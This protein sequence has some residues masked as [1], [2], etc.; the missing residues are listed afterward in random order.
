MLFEPALGFF[1]DDY[2]I[3]VAFLFAA[4]YFVV[5]MPPLLLLWRRAQGGRGAAP[6]EVAF[7]AA[8]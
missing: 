4:G 1:T 7:E 6:R 8:G 3:R 2:S 5:L